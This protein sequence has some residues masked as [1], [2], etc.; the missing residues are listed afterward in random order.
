MAEHPEITSEAATKPANN[1]VLQPDILAPVPSADPITPIVALGVPTGR[2]TLTRG[3][4]SRKPFEPPPPLPLHQLRHLHQ[5][6]AA[7]AQH[8]DLRS[9]HVRRGLGELRAARLHALVV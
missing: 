7:V 6:A 8:R 2:A 5:V 1:C 3:S 4:A 9:G